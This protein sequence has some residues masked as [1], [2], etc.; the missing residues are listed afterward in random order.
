[1]D[2]VLVYVRGIPNLE[3]LRQEIQSWASHR[4]AKQKGVYRQFKI[5]D[6]RG[7]HGSIYPKYWATH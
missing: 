4:N 6:A 5:D 1:M 3:V 7:K 2:K